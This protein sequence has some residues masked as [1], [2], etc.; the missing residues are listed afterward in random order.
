MKI[1]VDIPDTA[2][3]GEIMR[4]LGKDTGSPITRAEIA[5]LTKLDNAEIRDK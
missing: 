5:T 4:T 3:R 2:F 1:R